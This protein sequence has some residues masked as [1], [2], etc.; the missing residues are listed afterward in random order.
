[1][2][3]KNLIKLK[4]TESFRKSK[5]KKGSMKR[6]EKQLETRKLETE[7]HEGTT[8]VLAQEERKKGKTDSQEQT[9]RKRIQG[10][11]ALW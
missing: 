7:R 3:A 5:S 9:R 10:G 8:A 6:K 1:L 4:K 2:R 11:R